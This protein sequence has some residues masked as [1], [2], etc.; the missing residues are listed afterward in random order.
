MDSLILI[1]IS[2]TALNPEVF[3]AALNS[4][5]RVQAI[6]REPEGAIEAEYHYE[7]ESVIVALSRS[8]R[9]IGVG[10]TGEPALRFCWELRR[11][12]PGLRLLDESYSF[13]L[14]L[15]EVQDFEDLV[16]ASET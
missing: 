6:R 14:E 10:G 5:P 8:R 11:L 7:S 4:M 16:R 15:D 2:G 9:H 12:I 3:A 13:D 1:P